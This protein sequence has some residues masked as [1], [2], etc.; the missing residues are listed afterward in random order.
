MENDNND[1]NKNPIP[2]GGLALAFAYED[3]S[4]R[5]TASEIHEFMESLEGFPDKVILY[6]HPGDPEPVEDNNNKIII[7]L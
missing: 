3:H 7:Y 4:D 1:N 2:V 6:V 5:M